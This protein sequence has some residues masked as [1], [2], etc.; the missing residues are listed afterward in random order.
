MFS[1]F[2][3]LHPLVVH[4]PIVL[5][6]LSVVL[7]GIL[8][9][10]DY[11]QIKWATLAVMGVAFLGSVFASYVFHAHI[12]ELNPNATKVFERHE[13][14]AFYTV[15]MSGITFLLQGI[16]LFYKL[17]QRSFGV[18]VFV[19]ALTSA[20]FL[21]ITGHQ[22]AKLVYVEGVG[23]QGKNL[24][25]GHSH[26]E[27]MED[28]HDGMDMNSG[29]TTKEMENMDHHDN[30]QMD[31]G[32]AMPG[33]DHSK[34]NM[35]A[36]N[37]TMKGM[38]HSKMNQPNN[39]NTSKGMEGVDHSKMNMPT[40]KATNKGMEG[41]DHSKMDMTPSKTT[42]KAMEGMDHAKMDMPTN[43]ADMSGMDHAKMNMPNST[44]SKGREGMDHSKMDMGGGMKGMG[45][46]KYDYL[47]DPTKP[48]DNNPAKEQAKPKQ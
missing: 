42:P 33:M 3:N 15:W 26:S 19:A 22:G 29:D 11:Y 47:I 21:S 8:L 46:M 34:M 45:Q 24:M 43:K 23:P 12:G 35:P 31:S 39:K 20:I 48:Y 13:Q 27:G 44:P 40:N 41:M 2:P 5:I 30:M 14:F 32:K 4:F 6:L 7:Q 36:D 17:N 10:K 16:G 37:S 1:D 25:K 38:D 18:I 28:S 9:F